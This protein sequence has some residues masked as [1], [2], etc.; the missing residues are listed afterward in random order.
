MWWV[1]FASCT[2]YQTKRKKKKKK[3]KDTLEGELKSDDVIKKVSGQSR[4]PPVTHP[5]SHAPTQ[6]RPASHTGPPPLLPTGTVRLAATE[7]RGE[8]GRP[9]VRLSMCSLV[10]VRHLRV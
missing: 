7:R 3:K 2:Y 10:P 1:F 9:R 6:S 4:I 5:A 8:S